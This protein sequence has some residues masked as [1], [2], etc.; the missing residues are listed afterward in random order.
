MQKTLFLLLCMF[1][2]FS[3][4]SK[5]TDSR[6][7]DLRAKQSD[8]EALRSILPVRA[9]QEENTIWVEF[10]NSPESAIITVKKSGGNEVF[11]KTFSSPELI[12][13]PLIQLS[14]EYVVEITYGDIIL[15]GEFII[16]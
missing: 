9:W 13:L 12:Q 16:E 3:A 5:T 11:S 8:Q 7:I 1:V 10:F 4:F 14:G 15:S 2:G 6:E